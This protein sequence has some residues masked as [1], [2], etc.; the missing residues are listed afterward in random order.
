MLIEA[1]FVYLL[2][3]VNNLLL[4]GVA[5]DELVEVGHDVHADGAGELILS[6][7]DGRHGEDDAGEDEQELR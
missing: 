6:L 7:G 1:S 5:G 2:D 4:G 3:K